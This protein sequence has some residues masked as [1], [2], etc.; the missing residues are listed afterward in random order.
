MAARW[1]T[2]IGRFGNSHR[3]R[4]NKTADDAAAMHIP[5]HGLADRVAAVADDGVCRHLYPL[6]LDRHPIGALAKVIFG[7]MAVGDVA[8]RHAVRRDHALQP[9]ANIGGDVLVLPVVESERGGPLWR[10]A[11]LDRDQA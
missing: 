8:A 3:I 1:P 2:L 7:A 10:A 5:H 4:G 9:G 6:A 11:N